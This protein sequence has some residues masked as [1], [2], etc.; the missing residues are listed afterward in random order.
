MGRNLVSFK[1]SGYDRERNKIW[2]ALWFATSFLIFQ[3]FWCPN[4]VRTLILKFF[5]SKV[6]KRV[7]IRNDVRIMWPWKLDLGD[8]CWL[9]EGLRIINLDR[10]SIGNDV[11]ISQQAMLCTGSH[12]HKKADFPYLNSP[13]SIRDGAWIGARAIVLAGANIGRCAVVA[14][15]EVVRTP[16][17]DLKIQISGIIRD[18]REPE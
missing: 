4:R 8:D 12:D 7:F 3:P 10:V 13:I 11:C 2:Q 17:P 5:G 16:L 9:G 15:G 14:A 18:L 6:G 1:S